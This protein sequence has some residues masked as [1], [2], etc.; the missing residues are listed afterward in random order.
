MFRWLGKIFATDKSLERGLGI[1][2]RTGDA[3]YYT[4]EEKARDRETK[5]K[6]K[7]TMI[8]NWIESSKSANISRRALAFLAGGIWAF[9]FIFSWV[10]QQIA[11]WSS[12]VDSEKLK[13]MTAINDPFLEKA[14]GLVLLVYGFYFAAPY[15]GAIVGT[16]IEK[17]T[18]KK[19][20]K[21]V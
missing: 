11:V 16:A 3:L 2:E 19:A 7:D 5:E 10:S 13:L 20:D 9:L 14:T 6:R 17:F 1:L 12:N 4:E 8:M 21:P 18:G 15:M